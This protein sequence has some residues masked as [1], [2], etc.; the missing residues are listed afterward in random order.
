MTSM[1]PNLRANLQSSFI[2]LNGRIL[3]L[4]LLSSSSNIFFIWLLGHR[5]QSP[6]LTAPS[7]SPLPSPENSF[8]DLQSNSSTFYLYALTPKFMFEAE[9]SPFNP[10]SHTQLPTGSLLD[11]LVDISDSTDT[12]MNTV[13]LLP[14]ITPPNLPH[15][16]S[17][18]D[19]RTWSHP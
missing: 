14:K 3:Y 18:T 10:G 1:L 4:G 8:G 5:P 12:Q 13:V 17:L 2:Q 19:Q 6:T 15:P 9:V 7:Q 16:P 11:P